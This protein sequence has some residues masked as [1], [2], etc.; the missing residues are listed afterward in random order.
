MHN[1]EKSLRQG[2]IE[3]T[4]MLGC[5]N[6]HQPE[7]ML[8]S[9]LYLTGKLIEGS[10][11]EKQSARAILKRHI[12]WGRNL[13]NAADLQARAAAA[14]ASVEMTGCMNCGIKD[15]WGGSNYCPHCG[16]A[17]GGCEE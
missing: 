17:R 4:V 2:L 7:V 1:A 15:A 13:L 6:A 8:A 3:N 11:S 12:G 9:L 14:N 16:T 10:T 5:D